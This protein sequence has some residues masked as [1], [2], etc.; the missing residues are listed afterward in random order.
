MASFFQP[1]LDDPARQACPDS[2][3]Q[4]YCNSV[5]PSH[6]LFN[7]LW[8]L[9]G[10]VLGGVSIVVPL[11]L[12]LIYKVLQRRTLLPAKGPVKPPVPRPTTS[13]QESSDRAPTRD[14]DAIFSHQRTG[15]SRLGSRPQSSRGSVTPSFRL[16]KTFR[17][18]SGIDGGLLGP[19][20][21]S[22]SYDLVVMPLAMAGGVTGGSGDSRSS[23]Q[24]FSSVSAKMS[25]AHVHME[26]FGNDALEEPH[27]SITASFLAQTQ[28]QHNLAGFALQCTT[29]RKP[30]QIERLLASLQAL[31]VS[32]ILL[33]HHDCEAIDKVDFS[34]ASGVMI[35]NAC[36]LPNGERRH[37]FKAR[38]LRDIMARCSAEREERPEFFAGF[39]DRW[40]TRPKAS[41][42]R[43]AVKIAE[44]FGAVI[45]HGPIEPSMDIKASSLSNPMRT[46]SAFEYLRRSE[47][48]ELQECWTTESRKTWIPGVSDTTD[49]AILPTDALDAIIPR[50][51]ELLRHVDVSQSAKRL[52]RETSIYTPSLEYLELAPKRASFWE[53]GNGGTSLSP[54]GC[55]PLTSEPTTE[56]FDAV[57]ETQVHLGELGMLQAIE[58]NDE[59]RLLASLRSLQQT[60]HCQGLVHDLISGLA[61]R[62]IRVFK[63]LKTGFQ[64]P[65]ADVSFWGVSKG[66]D[67]ATDRCVDIFISLKAPDDA[68]AVLHT[69][70]AHNGV[71][72]E[73]RFEEELRLEEA[74]NTLDGSG[75]PVSIRESIKRGT[76]GE[77]LSLTQKLRVSKIS[78]P[79]T[80]AASQYCRSLL[81][82]ETS[83]VAWRRLCARAALDDSLSM[84]DVLKMRL[85]HFMR[86]GADKLPAL[87]N[88]V[89]LYEVTQ[90]TVDEALFFGDRKVL[91]AMTQ[92][93]LSSFDPWKSENNCDY[94]DVNADL[95][96]LIFFKILRR[97]AF[98]DVYLETTDR[99]PLF[100]SEPDQAAVFSELWILGS[101]CQIYFDLLPRDIGQVISKRYR[102]LLQDDPPPADYRRGKEIMTMYPSSDVRPVEEEV[103]RTNPSS[104]SL[105]LTAYERIQKWKKQF[106]AAGAL[107]IFC[108]PAIVDVTLLTFVGRGC[109]M[110][111]FM[112]PDHLEVSGF[113]LLAAMLLTAGVTGWVGST[114]NF[115]LAHY[116]YDNM[117]YFHVQRLSGGFVLTLAVGICG[118]IAFSIQKSVGAGFVFLAY[119][120]SITTYFNV[121]GIMS[122]MHLHEAPLSSGRLVVLQTLPLLLISPILSTFVNGNDLQIYIPV[123]YAFLFIVLFRY[124][125]LC[126]EWSNWMEKIPKFAEADIV[127]WYSMKLSSDSTDSD[128][129]SSKSGTGAVAR[130]AFASAVSAYTR[131]TRD[132]KASGIMSDTLVVRVANGM[133]YINWLLKKLSVEG[134]SPPEFTTAWFTQLGEAINQQR[135]LRR[136]LKEQSVF[137]L[138]RLARHDVGQNLGLFLIALMDRWLMLVMSAR[139][140]Y[141]S[142][143][144]DSRARYGIWLTIV[145]FCA[146][147]ILLDSTLQ[148]YWSHRYEV[149]QE[150]L[151][152]LEDAERVEAQAEAKRRQSIIKAI[153]DVASKLFV[154]F[155]FTTVMLWLLVE[156]KETFIIY[157][158][159]VFGY[160]GA[161]AFQFNRCFTTNVGAHITVIMCSA[162]IGFILGCILHALPMTAGFLYTDI[163]SQNVAALLAAVGTS[164]YSWKDPRASTNPVQAPT[165]GQ[166]LRAQP[167]ITAEWPIDSDMT[168]G[169]VPEEMTTTKIWHEDGSAAA[170]RITELL[171]LS[172]RDPSLHSEAVKWSSGLVRKAQQLWHA[173][174]ITI[175]I[176]SCE[177]FSRAGLGDL[178]SFSYHDADVLHVGFGAMGQSE[179]KI[180]TWQPMLAV[181]MCE[182]L[183]YHLARSELKLPHA[184]AVQA[185]HFVHGT[186][187]LSKRIQLELSPQNSQALFRVALKTEMNLM[188]HLCLGI[189]VN[190]KWESTPQTVREVIL[191]RIY[192][193]GVSI[194]GE[195][196]AWLAETQF[197]M[198]SADFHL[199]LTLQIYR[200]CRENLG[201]VVHFQPPKSHD[202][203]VFP[204][205]LQATSIPS[206]HGQHWLFSAFRFVVTACS[207]LVKWFAILSGAGSNIERELTYSLAGV[208]LR[209]VII[210]F[211]LFLWKMCWIIKNTWVYW[212]ILHDKPA[213]L[214]IARLAKKGERRKIKL[215][216]GAIVV[217]QPRKT[218][219][220]FVSKGEDGS[221]LLTVHNGIL[222]EP[223][224]EEDA[225]FIASY[226]R[227][228]RLETRVEKGS[229]RAAI[230]QYAE[231]NSS[232]QPT[233]IETT[234]KSGMSSTGYYDK[235]GRI[236][237]GTMSLDGKEIAFQY[238]YRAT[239]KGNA[240]LLRADYKPADSATE[241]CLS[242]FWGKPA[243]LESYDWV[244][245]QLVHLIIQKIDGRT[246]V[247]EYDYQHRR[248]PTIV[249][250]LQEADGSKTALSKRPH[251]FP[252][253][254]KLLVRPENVSFDSEDLLIYHNRLQVREMR[255]KANN[256]PTLV[257]YLN[258]LFWI[259]QWNRR[260]YKRMPTWRVRTELW[261]LWVKST[262]LDAFTACWVDEL[263]LREEPLLQAYWRARDSG[264]LEEARKALDD[265]IDHI[266]SAINIDAD[267]SEVSLLAIKT[268]DLYAMGLGN[269]ANPVTAQPENCY[270]DT[271]DRISVIFND[272]GCWPVSPG[273]VSNCRRDLVNGHTTIRNHVLAECANDYG[274][275]R[276][277][278]EKSVQSMK[279][280]PLWGLDG[281]TANH[282]LVDNLLQSQVDEKIEATDMDADV[283]GIFVP[284][285]TEF[286]K[287]ARTKQYSRADLIKYSNVYLSMAKYYETKDYGLTWKSPVVQRAWMR[288]WLIRYDDDNIA[289]VSECFEMERPSMSDFRDAL[290]I[291]MAYLFIYAVQIPEDCPRVFQSTHH[292]ISSLFGMILQCR[293]DVTFGIW[294]HAILWRETCLNISPAQSELPLAV[295]SMLLAGIGMAAR[296]AYFHADVIM[297]CASVFNPMW[298]VEL[299]TDGGNIASRNMFERKVDPIVNG[300]SNMDAFKPVDKVRT[301]KPTVVM[302]SNVQFIKGVKIAIQAAD[303]IV[304]EMGFEDYQLVVYGAKDRQPA[305]CLEMEKLIVESGLAGKV[306]LA[307]FGNPKVVLQDAWLFMNSSIS[308]GLPLAIG[309]AALA[310]VP[311]VATEVGA[312]ALVLTDPQDQHQQYGEV[313]PPNDPMAL[314]R[315]QLSILSMVGPW[316]KF[317]EEKE[318]EAPTLPDEILPEHVDWLTKRFYERA[319]DRRK[320]GLLSREVVLH[321]FHGNR[322]LREHEQMYWIQWHM[323]QMR[324]NSDL[325]GSPFKFG[326]PRP[327]RF[328][329][330]VADEKVTEDNDSEK[331][332]ANSL[333]LRKRHQPEDK[334]EGGNQV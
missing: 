132:A 299:G 192:G 84:R 249:S 244:P 288:A 209:G 211:I 85:D 68:A 243:D 314:A 86:Q 186:D 124:R 280:L 70:L 266:V 282:G 289:D 105:D 14:G 141:P 127:E 276:F 139:K 331:E 154:V 13:K 33:C 157:Y 194:S 27:L 238:H 295:Q 205:D 1:G 177:D 71:L 164:Y 268:S 323:S 216:R 165:K 315:A 123:M 330:E 34:L 260:L 28:L 319:E 271:E 10:L 82:E 334:S 126:Q 21:N 228:L 332:R 102:L 60:T 272:I 329:E 170:E 93:L 53:S 220:G 112:E 156:S 229:S 226:D 41:V 300:I 259:A 100:L 2:T 135:V 50:A 269:D 181:M 32:V 155:G 273:G 318:A 75:L 16:T 204:A 203:T 30:E 140:P 267:V 310:G 11:T 42:I 264:R 23:M 95:F 109:F 236:T 293:R 241:D 119:L 150:R 12:Y 31:D 180:T 4:V 46:M 223:L 17:V 320:L 159:Y 188:K 297:P 174:K 270:K 324:A 88:L 101:Q 118:L 311:I 171:R 333:V 64:I 225:L 215:N 22:R 217:E 301:D 183:M 90:K 128:T 261:S 47:L 63:G 254:S 146:A 219:T 87:D 37:Y 213:L 321:S 248:D 58:G 198:Q 167:K 175:M 96:A 250:H 173:R 317:T 252:D 29:A 327:L 72:R 302:L 138:F 258:P 52:S 67:A 103:D 169:H 39:M 54:L 234:F 201:R 196:A 246:Y 18:V 185:E 308:E 65:R 111:A 265:K 294:D 147:A 110:T 202:L 255:R 24:S 137:T 151:A 5:L 291:Y 80:D 178:A 3:F 94:I 115:Y 312:T 143:Y 144:T 279:L 59:Q 207:S 190:S 152:G 210:W 239:P 214:N 275:P 307:G 79:M 89:R 107:S 262:T 184:Q 125:R 303:I 134:S 113:A 298:E 38:R 51:S 224:K 153:A 218:V 182:S 57:V 8:Q 83:K 97:S 106:A 296:L 166:A 161:I 251:L 15:S 9:V 326:T 98:E 240:D 122:T 187:A 6:S 287:G 130:E 20:D 56:Q 74:N 304:N 290:G 285:L 309:E 92:T 257:T 36:I 120:V 237:K 62:Q 43:R 263:I 149:S 78:H 114:G 176:S 129:S 104:P 233:S 245:S 142:I 221:M 66:R 145:Y 40:E 222:K 193:E 91:K 253:D 231:N 322:Y 313:V 305:Y 69:W 131:R 227:D 212:I 121:F 117:I 158:M 235:Y 256:T 44:H 163:V 328:I 281:N 247:T 162:A 292:G 274:I 283:A 55:F 199:N 208:P 73:Q 325:N 195:F 179:Q 7:N 148:K 61:S 45:D 306:V 197:D 316:A 172:V 277:Q 19:Q 136:G 76:Y 230:Y 25:L 278:I 48:I 116:A 99:C 189:D 160:T 200:Q 26:D 286:V 206:S 191:D 232:R 168:S 133:P 242:V 77:V 284:L 108:L 81:I 49:V 35:E